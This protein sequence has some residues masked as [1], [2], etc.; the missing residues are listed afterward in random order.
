[1]V[2]HITLSLLCLRL[3]STRAEAPRSDTH[4]HTRSLHGLIR[5]TEERTVV[6]V[7][8]LDRLTCT[9][10][11]AAHLQR[12]TLSHLTP[13]LADT[14]LRELYNTL[15]LQRD[16]ERVRAGVGARVSAMLSPF[17]AE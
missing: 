2:F 17:S 16:R 11:R 8:E 9:C 3:I 12:V 7:D 14:L 5:R 4:Q 10:A 6:T 15:L 13:V 1:M